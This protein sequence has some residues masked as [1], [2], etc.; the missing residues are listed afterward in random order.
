[1]QKFLLLFGA[2]LSVCVLVQPSFTDSPPCESSFEV[3]T[4]QEP[5]QSPPETYL[6]DISLFLEETLFTP[7]ALTDEDAVLKPKGPIPPYALDRA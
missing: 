2:L 4:M 5:D 3:A 1:M 6:D 7:G